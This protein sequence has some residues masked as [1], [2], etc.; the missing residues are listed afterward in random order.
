MSNYFSNFPTTNHDLTNDGQKVR[1]TNILRRFKIKSSVKS[2]L[3]VY[4][5]YDVQAGDRPDTIA[6]KYYGSSAHAWI[7][8]HFNDIIDPM[9]D[10]PLFNEDFNNYIKGKY[11]SIPSS[12]A[13]THEYRQ[14]LS[15]AK[16]LNNGTRIP[17]RWV[18][19]DLTTYNTLVDADK[20]LITKYDYEIELNDEKRK[21]QILDK[22]YLNQLQDEV[23]DILRNGI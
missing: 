11:G 10:W 14:I 7:V 16:V 2:G 20:E 3:D 15:E 4:Y 13:T 22:R 17:K 18:V 9:F 12:K 5:E 19:I 8:L 21:I 23:R 1:L 6:E